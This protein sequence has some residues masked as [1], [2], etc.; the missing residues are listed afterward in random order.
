MKRRAKLKR[1]GL[2]PKISP[3]R[4][5]STTRI[6]KKIL[7]SGSIPSDPFFP[8]EDKDSYEALHVEMKNKH[9]PVLIHQFDSVERATELIWRLRKIAAWESVFFDGMKRAANPRATHVVDVSA[10]FSEFLEIVLCNN[11]LEKIAKYEAKLRDQAK[12]I[13]LELRELSVWRAANGLNYPTIEF[14]LADPPEAEI[15]SE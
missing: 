12:E 13:D 7:D 10:R 2:K 11:G 9:Q 14:A 5:R 8:D 15:G 4:Y 6:A 3:L 1:R